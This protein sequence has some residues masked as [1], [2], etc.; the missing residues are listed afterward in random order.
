MI[1]V[2][3]RHSSW[4]RMWWTHP[5]LSLAAVAAAA[6]LTVL[7]VHAAT[8]PLP[9]A[10]EQLSTLRPDHG[11]AGHHRGRFSP[12]I[13]GHQSVMSE[14]GWAPAFLVSVGLWVLM[15]TAM[16][17]PTALPQARSISLNG[18]WKRRQRG[19]ALFAIGYLAVWSAV[20]VLLLSAAWL[21]GAKA[22]SPLAISGALAIAAAWESTRWKRL[23]LR[24]LP[25]VA[26]VASR[27]VAS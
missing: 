25:S 2:L 9:I 12:G 16:M 18:K 13:A 26:V 14:P 10:A 3:P 7:T 19:P 8:G 6:W 22:T 27:R 11:M 21:I 23:C 20:G 24:C 15:A 4:R 1:T 17:L 5:E